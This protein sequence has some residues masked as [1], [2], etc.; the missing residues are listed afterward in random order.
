MDML[1]RV[2]A[3]TTARREVDRKRV[4][5]ASP[6]VSPRDAA[7]GNRGISGCGAGT[8]GTDAPP[9]SPRNVR[10]LLSAF[11]MRPGQIFWTLKRWTTT[12]SRSGVEH[13]QPIPAHHES[14][15]RRHVRDRRRRFG[16]GPSPAIEMGAWKAA[17]VLP[18]SSSQ[19]ELDV[20]LAK[21]RV[22]SANE[23]RALRTYMLQ[24][25]AAYATEA[26]RASPALDPR[27]VVD[28]RIFALQ[29]AY[30]T[31]RPESPTSG[32][33]TLLLSVALSRQMTQAFN[34]H[35]YSIQQKQDAHDYYVIIRSFI[36][37]A[38]QRIPQAGPI[39][40]NTRRSLRAFA[41]AFLVKDTAVDPARVSWDELP[42]VGISTVECQVQTAMARRALSR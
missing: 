22:P 37:P 29:T 14:R 36:L 5:A 10:S 2:R 32:A 6:G 17:L 27:S 31:V 41:R 13:H 9:R 26:R 38:V 40:A 7:L 3:D 39:D 1:T 12:W 33:A 35:H 4:A 16:G 30:R 21:A 11:R 23:R 20:F 42:C 8:H 24:R 19:H 34:A 15:L 25:F 18:P 28:A